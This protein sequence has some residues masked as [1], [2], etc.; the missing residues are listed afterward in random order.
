MTIHW[1]SFSPGHLFC[2][3]SILE[4][5]CRGA[6]L[7]HV[8]I[9]KLMNPTLSLRRMSGTEGGRGGGGGGG[10]GARL[11]LG[12]DWSNFWVDRWMPYLFIADAGFWTL[13][14][15]KERV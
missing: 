12:A 5:S 9:R 11:W 4:F 10:E 6:R 7:K 14:R 15:K 13:N 2:K 1:A 8:L 3:A